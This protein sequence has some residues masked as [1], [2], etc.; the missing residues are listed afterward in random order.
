MALIQ[1]ALAVALIQEAQNP[2]FPR[3]FSG[4]LGI[5]KDM[6]TRCFG[7]E[8]ECASEV[9]VLE[10]WSPVWG[11]WEVHKPLRDRS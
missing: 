4:Q 6:C 3:S 11:Y 9:H 1:E 7:L 5:L 8:L 2:H 10:V